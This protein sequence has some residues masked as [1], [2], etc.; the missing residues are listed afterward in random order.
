M[1][2]KAIFYFGADIQGKTLVSDSQFATFCKDVITPLFKGFTV[3]GAQGYW[4]GKPEPT[5]VVTILQTAETVEFFDSACHT[6]A[7]AYALQFSQES[8]LVE[9][10][11]IRGIAFVNV[12][13]SEDN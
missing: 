4:E 3:V 5:R 12:K 10:T 8:V 6:I 2:N 9:Y 11:W 13:N 7:Q 1:A